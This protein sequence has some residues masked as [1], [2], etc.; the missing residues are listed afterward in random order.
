M[1]GFSINKQ[2]GNQQTHELNNPYN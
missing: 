1:P 2:D